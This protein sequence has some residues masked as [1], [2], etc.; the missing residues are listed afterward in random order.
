MSISGRIPKHIEEL[1]V[2]NRRG[3]LKSAGLL[4]VSFGAGLAEADAQ[5]T[6]AP[7]G[8]GPYPT[9]DF[10]QIDSWIVIHPDNTAIFYVGKTDPGQGTGTG[11]RQLMSDE[12]DIAFDKTTCIMG[13]TDITVDQVGSGGSTA[14]E[15]DSWPMRRVAAEAR[16]VLLEMGS[17]RLGVPV[18][19]LAVNSAVITA[20]ADPSKRVTYGELIGGKKFNITLNGNSINA[21]TGQAKTKLVPELKYTGQPLHRDDIPAKVDGSL[22]WAVDVKLPGMV[23]ARNVKPPFACA[24]LTGIDE[25]S[26]KGLPGFIKVVS[27]GNYVAVVC[28]REEQ[29]IRAARQ[30][31]TTWEKP[32]TA[33]FPSSDDLFN[34]MRKATPASPGRPAGAGDVEARNPV[35]APVGSGSA[36]AANSKAAATIEAEYEIPFQG[37][38]AFAGAHAT[39]DPSNG[40]M[41]I[42]SNDMKSY[43]MRRGV[44]TFLGMPQDRVR[45]VYMQGPQGFGRTAAEDAAC[46]AAYIAREIGHPVRMQWMRDEETAWDTKSPAFLVKM[47]GALDAQGRLIGYEYN[48]RSCD[49]NHLGYNEPDTVLIAQLMG[50]RRA[51]PASGSAS[52]PSDVYVIPNRKMAGEVV[53]LPIVWETPLRTGN[54]RDPNGP[55]ATFASESFIDEVAAAAKID[56]LEFRMKL[57]Q[58]GAT[59]DGG[60]RRARSLAVLKAAAEK[61]GWDSRPSP[62]ARGNGNIFT[63]RGIAYTFRGQTI[64]AQI[65]E[66]EV[67]RKTGHVWAKRIVCAHDCGLIVNP[68]NLHHAVECGTL[69]GLSR[70]IHEEVRFDTEKVTSRDWSSH[71]TLRHADVP[72]SIDIVLVNGDP[73]PNRPDLPPYGAGEASLKPTMAAIAN[74]IY[75]ATGVRIRRV[76]FRDDRV[77]AALKAAG[78]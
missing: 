35:A 40:Q 15:R 39:A 1:L 9:P 30:L 14:M 50:S 2:T 47:R 29:A 58:A 67:N 17:V 24:K 22:K 20:K 37:H 28:E 13:S 54:L 65:A 33:P 52:M 38:T 62:K 68:E 31:K 44:A 70:A 23:H 4:A 64:V 59:D 21:V 76:P 42:Y 51:R 66:V 74:A 32:P 7:Q 75:D 16:R 36:N 57:L 10:H 45:V 11:F 69:H 18:D 12:L 49:Y 5:T 46:E 53:G 26:V 77:L 25:S 60:F 19:Q 34:Y 6:S 3:F 72:E 8:P 73:N 48:A 55:Q 61:Y 56:P 63:G 78:V 41:T 27:K 71:P 43:G